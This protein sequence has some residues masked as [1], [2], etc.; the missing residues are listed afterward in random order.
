MGSEILVF[1]REKLKKEWK[2]AFYSAF[3]MGLLVHLYKFTNLLP[4]ADALYNFYSSQNMVAS[5]RWFLSVACGFSSYFD[6]PWVNG[7]LSLVFMGITAAVIAEVFRMKNP[8]LILLSSGLQVS[9]PAITATMSYEFTA[10][11]YMIAMALA[12]LSVVLTRMEY[13][14]K[15]HWPKMVLSAL[16]I[17]LS[18]AIY[19]AYV[20]FAFVLAVCYFMTELLENRREEKLYWRWIGTQV[21]VYICALAAYYVIWKLCLKLQGFSAVSYQGIDTVGVMGAAGILSGFGKI[22]RDFVRFFLEWNILEHGVTVYSMLNILFLLAFGAGLVTAMVKSGIFRRKLH[23]VLLVLCVAALPVGCYIWYLTSPDVFYHALMLQ[24]VCL[25]YVLT[26]VLVD[27]WVCAPGGDAIGNIVL[28]L[29]TAVV[30][31]NSVTANIYYTYMD[32]SVRNTQAAAT[33]LS[34]RIH[35]LDDGTVK[36][37]AIYGGLDGYTQE[38]HFEQDKL[39]QLGGWKVLNRTILSPLYL[40]LYTD[41]DL[42]YYRTNELDYPVVENDPDIPAPQDW[43]FR[44]PLLEKTGRDAL[45]RTE[46]VQSMPIWPARDSV[47]V[48]GDTIVVK[49]SETEEM[50]KSD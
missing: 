40:S 47:Q 33:E 17:C 34:T 43:T 10:D 6:L 36:Y 1:Y 45:A 27:R 49:L 42:S 2:L 35:L 23:L 26:A 39:R 19:Q 18:C 9:F 20:S 38:D 32:Q 41:F 12:A 29:L 30:F 37:L 22:A 24:S 13:I 21:I 11:G 5:G 46:Q 3:V 14:G 28:I 48:I 8:V 4:N 44:F 16:C 50:M 7:L 15:R 31:N 25:L